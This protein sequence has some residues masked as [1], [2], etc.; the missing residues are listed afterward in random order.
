MIGKK[1]VSFRGS[2]VIR[3]KWDVYVESIANPSVRKVIVTSDV[4]PKGVLPEAGSTDAHDVL[5]GFSNSQVR[6]SGPRSEM[7]RWKAELSPARSVSLNV[8]ALSEICAGPES[9]FVVYPWR[10][11]SS[12]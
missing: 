4:E 10:R 2:F 12:T 11:M 6:R 3:R 1:I 5:F 7:E 9:L 8:D